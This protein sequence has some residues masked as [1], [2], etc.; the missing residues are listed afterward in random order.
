MV[1]LI[2]V[3]TAA[4][5]AW[6]AR[7]VV[8]AA[9]L[10]V[11][12]S[13][14]AASPAP[15]AVVVDVQGRVRRPGIVRLPA[16]SRVVQAVRAAGGTVAG[17]DTAS[18]NLAR[19]LT[20]GEQLLVGPFPPVTG[21][22]GRGTGPTGPGSAGPEAAGAATVVDLNT[23]STEQLEELPGVGPV[24]AQRILDWRTEHGRFSSVDDLQEVNGIGAR[25]F[26]DLK[27]RVR[28]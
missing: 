26:E 11:V 20:D 27:D 16:G 3:V 22:A 25:R 8:R 2:A 15:P 4:V 14:A 23:A 21:P 10:P 24:L 18:L 6:R 5:F 12:T 9:P 1:G 19:I 7:P 13:V 17:T 28:V